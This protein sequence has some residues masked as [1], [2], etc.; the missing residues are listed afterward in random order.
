MKVD[1]TIFEL[2]VDAGKPSLL[3]GDGDVWNESLFLQALRLC[4]ETGNRRGEC[5][6]KVEEVLWFAS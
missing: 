6:E 2:S 3:N 4:P 1:N 5:P